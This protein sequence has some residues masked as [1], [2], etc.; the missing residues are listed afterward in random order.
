[1]IEFKLKWREVPCTGEPCIACEE[2]IYGKQYQLH[3]IIGG[4]ATPLDQVAC[5]SC[6][7]EIEKEGD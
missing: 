6:Y 5:A 2:P 4:K 3:T 7:M 1:M